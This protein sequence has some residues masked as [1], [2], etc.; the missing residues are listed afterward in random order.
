MET[1]YTPLNIRSHNSLLLGLSKPEQITKKLQK[2]EM[3]AAALS[4]HN[5]LSGCI[6]FYKAMK[7]SGQKCILGTQLNICE[8]ASTIQ[9]KENRL[10]SSL[11]LVAK[12]KVGWKNLIK[13]ISLSNQPDRFYHKARLSLD[14]LG[15][16]SE[17]LI[18]F[19]GGI[20]SV[21][22]NN[23]KQKEKLI[24][25]FGKENFFAEIQLFH[26]E[27]AGLGKSVRDLVAGDGIRCIA[28]GAPYYC[29][30]EDAYDQ[31]VLLCS[32]MA[33]T[34]PQVQAKLA[35]GDEG[36]LANFFKSDA[37][38]LPA[39]NE[40]LGFG[41]TEEEL[42]NTNLIADMCESYDVLSKPL[43][44]EF[45]CPGGA[46]PDD[47]LRHLCREGWKKKIATKI[48][49]DQHGSYAD[50]V[51]EELGILQGAGLSSYFLI[52]N[53]ICRFIQS[54][55]WL[56]NV[57]RGSAAG[58]L[59]S[60]LT[61]ITQVDPI[62]YGLLFS[63]FYNEGRNTKDRVSMPDIDLDVPATKR[64][65]VIGHIKDLHGEKKVGQI[66][67]FQTMKG[68]GAMKE[69]LRAYGTTSFDMMNKVT[70]HIPDESKIVDDLQIMK[71][72][73]GESSIIK[74]ALENEPKKFEEWVVIKDDGSFDG[75]LAKRFEQA[76]RLEGTRK[77]YGKHASGIVISTEDL[78]DMCPL[79][80]DKK[81]GTMMAGYEMRNLEDVGGV[82]LDILGLNLMDKIQGV[83]DVLRF[84]G[85]SE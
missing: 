48:P 38:F 39:Y 13:L 54:N 44:P 20:N 84:G 19:S 37:F 42:A 35:E 15:P 72:E 27:S 43:L 75:P 71:E 24:S 57:G 14:D 36:G 70:E 68:R 31:R 51:K 79:V 50:R 61:D 64:D 2:L 78:G 56:P 53:D 7:K 47:Y 74:W 55:G 21:L 17:G 65:K 5:S 32:S 58:C 11:N 25:L 8:Q 69:V 67:A 4:D 1:N 6:D 49:K 62:R 28:T 23:S 9:E 30:R 85:I 18:C 77:S 73:E 45:K 76:I 3:K 46:T 80:L 59:V 66:C 82:K 10:T 29:N 60:Y 81:N 22:A 16:Y 26:A 63:R 12:N 52:L 33:T 34:F 40:M 83:A 41:H